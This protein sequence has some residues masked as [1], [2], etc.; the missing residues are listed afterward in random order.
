MKER[1]AKRLY[2]IPEASEYLGRSIWS[3]R[4]LIWAGQLPSV[5]TGRRVHIDLHDMDS[6]IDRH[7][8]MEDQLTH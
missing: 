8:V 5:K 1:V 6:F 4:R 3:V 2:S 7:K